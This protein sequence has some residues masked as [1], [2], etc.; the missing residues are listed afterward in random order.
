M[1]VIR[2]LEDE[3]VP[4]RHEARGN[5]HRIPIGESPPGGQDVRGRRAVEPDPAA[6]VG[7]PATR[8]RGL[9]GRAE[10][11]AVRIEERTSR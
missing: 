3:F 10:E 4:T 6:V 8:D 11:E 7:C 1:A 9:V 5:G 2:D